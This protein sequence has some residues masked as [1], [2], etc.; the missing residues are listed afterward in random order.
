L[1]QSETKED[2]QLIITDKY[3]LFTLNWAWEMIKEE[4]YDS[5]LFQNMDVE[6]HCSCWFWG[7]LYNHFCCLCWRTHTRIVHCMFFPL[8]SDIFYIHMHTQ[9]YIKH[10]KYKRYE[11]NQI[12]QRDISEEKW[13][14]CFRYSWA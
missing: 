6:L 14:E 13:L 10:T 7:T 11:S 9:T 12:K 3:T 1:K 2:K 4:I 5:T 8:P